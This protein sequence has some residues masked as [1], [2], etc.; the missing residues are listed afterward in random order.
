[1]SDYSM[2]LDT[3]GYQD[4]MAV[5]ISQDPI[6][7]NAFNKQLSEGAGTYVQRLAAIKGMKVNGTTTQNNGLILNADFSTDKLVGAVFAFDK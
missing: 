1:P 6:D 5:V 7:Y 3:E 4:Q 2:E